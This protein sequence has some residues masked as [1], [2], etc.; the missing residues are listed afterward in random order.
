MVAWLA[1]FFLWVSHPGIANPPRFLD[2]RTEGIHQRSL[3]NMQKVPFLVKYTHGLTVLKQT[4][5]KENT[6]YHSWRS[7][8][9]ET[10]MSLQNSILNLALYWVSSSLP[11]SLPFLSSLWGPGVCTCTFVLKCVET[12]D[13]YPG[14]FLNRSSLLSFKDRVSKWNLESVNSAGLADQPQVTSCFLPL[15]L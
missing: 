7:H 1:E 5:I 15:I 12:R 13:W 8:S 11:P 3:Q 6:H 4:H 14:V 10:L 9:A 2:T